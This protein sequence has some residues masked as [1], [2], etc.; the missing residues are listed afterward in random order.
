MQRKIGTEFEISNTVSP[1]DSHGKSSGIDR[2]VSNYTNA[3]EKV[4]KIKQ[5]ISTGT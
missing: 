4:Q 3:R 5:L 1:F 2:S